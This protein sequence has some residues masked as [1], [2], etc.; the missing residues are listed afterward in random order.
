MEM[1]VKYIDTDDYLLDVRM[2]PTIDFKILQCLME[3]GGF[4][5]FDLLNYLFGDWLGQKANIIRLGLKNHD[6]DDE[7]SPAINYFFNEI[8]KNIYHVDEYEHIFIEFVD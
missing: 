4:G 1:E 5:E 8:L 3:D 6:D 2:V 7:S